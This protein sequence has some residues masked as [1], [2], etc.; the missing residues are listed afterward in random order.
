MVRSMVYMNLC[1]EESL[2]CHA[3]LWELTESSDSNVNLVKNLRGIM[4][5]LFHLE[6][7]CCLCAMYRDFQNRRPSRVSPR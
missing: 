1:P 3:L 6:E 5:A 2:K 4:V 7:C